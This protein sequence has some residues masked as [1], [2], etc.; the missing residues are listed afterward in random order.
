MK[1]SKKGKKGNVFSFMKKAFLEGDLDFLFSFLDTE[2]YYI[3]RL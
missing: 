1:N 3:N 2:I